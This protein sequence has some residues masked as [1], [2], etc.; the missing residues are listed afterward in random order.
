MTIKDKLL[1]YELKKGSSKRLWV[2]DKLQVLA[3]MYLAKRNNIAIEKAYVKYNEGKKF[4]VTLT[5]KSEKEVKSILKQMRTIDS[6]PEKCNN[7][8]KCK[9]CNLKEYCWL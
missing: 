9:G 3:Y 2:N 5:N 1:L 8:N 7:R 6:L 4:E